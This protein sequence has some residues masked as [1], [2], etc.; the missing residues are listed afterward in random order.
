MSSWPV[1]GGG[2]VIGLCEGHVAT[3][4]CFGCWPFEE[5][6]GLIHQTIVV[7]M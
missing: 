5:A 4:T 6:I 3:G 7:H 1:C 2:T